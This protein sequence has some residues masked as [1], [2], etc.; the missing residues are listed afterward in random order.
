MKIVAFIGS[1]G[2]GKSYRAMFVARQ[3]GIDYLIDDGLLI[4][5]N[6]VLAGSSAK[7]ERTKLASVRRALFTSPE[8]AASVR[9]A[10]EREAPEGIL[11]L[12]TSE[13]MV[14]NIIR[15]L[16]LDPDYQL[17]KIEDVANKSEIELATKIRTEQGKHVIPVPAVELKKDF[18]GYFLD[19]LNLFRKSGKEEYRA[20]KSIVRPTYS[21]FGNYTVSPDAVFQLVA[22]EVQKIN[23]IKRLLKFYAEQTE[24]GISATLDIEVCYPAILPALGAEVKRRTKYVLEEFIALNVYAVNVNIKRIVVVDEA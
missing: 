18:S 15:A 6:K 23:R 24:N 7:A 3:N 20:E 8:H 13:K 4:K 16:S 14:Q 12:G 11:I 17:I 2:T 19:R 21:Y 22:I 5:G 1:S 9:K 10:I